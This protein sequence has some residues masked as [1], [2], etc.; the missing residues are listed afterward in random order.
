[1]LSSLIQLAL[2]GESLGP[3]ILDNLYYVGVVQAFAQTS[4]ASAKKFDMRIIDAL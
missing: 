3:S 4:Q 2:Y 1:L